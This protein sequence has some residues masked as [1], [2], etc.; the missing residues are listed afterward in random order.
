MLC[1]MSLKMK[2]ELQ[3]A[4]YHLLSCSTSRWIRNMEDIN[5][6]GAAE[7]R[8]LSS[9]WREGL[10]TMSEENQEE[11]GIKSIET[12]FDSCFGSKLPRF[13]AFSCYSP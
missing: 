3:G 11:R 10:R 9:T 13:P 8:G 2:K 12:P 4:S 7:P 5:G 6:P 1:N